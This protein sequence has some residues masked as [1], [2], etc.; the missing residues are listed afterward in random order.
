MARCVG[1]YPNKSK[2]TIIFQM[3]LLITIINI[4]FFAIQMEDAIYGDNN[5][6][7]GHFTAPAIISLLVNFHCKIKL[8]LSS[9]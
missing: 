7:F 3:Y 5:P 2:K 9:N 6:S 8:L 4:V 1:R